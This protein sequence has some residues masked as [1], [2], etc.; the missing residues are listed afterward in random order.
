MD[1]RC[2]L[3]HASINLART[4]AAKVIITLPY[5]LPVRRMLTENW[6]LGQRI[7]QNSCWTMQPQVAYAEVNVLEPYV[8]CQRKLFGY[9]QL[10][11]SGVVTVGACTSAKIRADLE[12]KS[13]LV[14]RLR[15]L[16]KLNGLVLDRNENLANGDKEDGQDGN[17]QQ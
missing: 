15:Q 1:V 2:I 4:Q 14:H 10:L 3:R 6:E 8:S 5:R 12:T 9:M 16:R 17:E 13:L 7:G 11:K